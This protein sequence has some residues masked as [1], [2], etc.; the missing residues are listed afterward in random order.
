MYIINIKLVHVQNPVELPEKDHRNQIYH[1][2]PL[3][4]R[5]DET[6]NSQ[7]IRALCPI[8]QTYDLICEGEGKGLHA[9]S[10]PENKM[11]GKADRSEV[12]FVE[13]L[14]HDKVY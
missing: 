6:S 8:Y 11:A 5:F 3:Q 13:E 12:R 10:S 7:T 2:L 9:H 14:Y 1:H 4:T